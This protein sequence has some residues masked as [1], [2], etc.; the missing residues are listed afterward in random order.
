MTN[1]LEQL[2]TLQGHAHA[3]YSKYRVAALLELDD[4]ELI[5]GVNVENASYGGTICAERTA[6]VSAVSRYGDQ[7]G[8]RALHLLAGDN[9][10][11]AMPCGFCRQVISE[12]VDA[13]FPIH[14]YTADGRMKTLSMAELLPHSFSS[15]DLGQL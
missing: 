8:F 4:G 9:T 11:F 7:K 2:K 12:F 1:Y 10:D 14:V 3:P 13:D 15:A 6:I 5:P